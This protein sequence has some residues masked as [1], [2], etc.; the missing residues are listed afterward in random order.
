MSTFIGAF[1][2]TPPSS[3]AGGEDFTNPNSVG[4]VYTRRVSERLKYAFNVFIGKQSRVPEAGT[5]RWFGMANYRTYAVSEERSGTFRFEVFDD[6]DRQR[7]GSAGLYSAAAGGVTFQPWNEVVLRPEV[8]YDWSS[9]SHPF[10]GC[11]DLYA[12]S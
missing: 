11:N 12:G 1:N 9:R 4:L 3:V 6:S 10:E 8:R 2:R 7:T 5:A